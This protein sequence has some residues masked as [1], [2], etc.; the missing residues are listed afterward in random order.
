MN[1]LLT[2]PQSEEVISASGLGGTQAEKGTF[3]QSSKRIYVKYLYS[4]AAYYM[5]KVSDHSCE[6]EIY[7]YLPCSVR[8]ITATQ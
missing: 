3:T 5:F 2:F 8:E 6:P 7:Y 1:E 4:A